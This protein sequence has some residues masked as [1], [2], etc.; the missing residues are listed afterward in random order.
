MKY[1][2]EGTH[3][4]VNKVNCGHETILCCLSN[5][6]KTNIELCELYFI[7]NPNTM[8]IIPNTSNFGYINLD[9]VVSNLNKNTNLNIRRIIK[10]NNSKTN[11]IDEIKKNNLV[12]L[13]V[14]APMLIYQEIKVVKYPFHMVIANGFDTFNNTIHI[15]DTFEN[16]DLGI[17]AAE[18]NLNM[19]FV[20]SHTIEYCVFERE[21][22][23]ELKILN[24]S[25][26]EKNIIASSDN[27]S[28]LFHNIDCYFKFLEEINMKDKIDS[29][30][31]FRWIVSGSFFYNLIEYVKY[32]EG[33]KNN[34]VKLQELYK[35]W[36]I[37]IWKYIKD[38]MKTCGQN[39]YEKN[40][41]AKLI[42]E[43]QDLVGVIY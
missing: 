33:L 9:D 16:D 13:Y 43:T 12:L 41:I 32:N 6:I 3:Y 4:A 20:L 24:Y 22:E 30:A 11:I 35:K 31:A 23:K 42:S 28:G 25:C 1:Q 34:L 37:L 2:I 27:K 21:K 38:C 7:T 5:Q 10:T 40:N 17:S 29:L 15:I 18:H 14:K 19:D 26:I 36:D 39:L 8:S